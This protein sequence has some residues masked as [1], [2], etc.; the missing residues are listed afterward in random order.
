MESQRLQNYC[1][2]SPDEFLKKSSVLKTLEPPDNFHM[3][4]LS[5]EIWHKF[6]DNKQ[7]IDEFRNKINLWKQLNKWIQVFD[8]FLQSIG[9]ILKISS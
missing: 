2:S 6:N 4:G 1:H 5:K 9:C 8:Y 7:T 3:Q